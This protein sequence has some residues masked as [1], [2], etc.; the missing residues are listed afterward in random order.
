[1]AFTLG[2]SE[3]VWYDTN[4]LAEKLGIK[5]QTLRMWKSSGA[6]PELKPKKIGGKVYYSSKNLVNV[7][8]A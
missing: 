1:M 8:Q 7:L 4:E 3:E 2:N 5:P 6:H